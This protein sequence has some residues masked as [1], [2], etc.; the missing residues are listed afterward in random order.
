MKQATHTKIIC[1]NFC[2]PQ[3][4]VTIAAEGNISNQNFSNE[5]DRWFILTGSTLHF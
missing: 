1:F 2:L 5:F 4:S 3:Q